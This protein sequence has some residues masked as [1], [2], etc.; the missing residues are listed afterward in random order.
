MSFGYPEL[1]KGK[2]SINFESIF[3]YPCSFFK[4][5][6]QKPLYT[7]PSDMRTMKSH[8]PIATSQI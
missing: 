6:L 8:D 7:T 1:F 3:K 5:R 4:A 2:V